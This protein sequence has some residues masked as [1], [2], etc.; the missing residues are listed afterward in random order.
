M[1]GFLSAPDMGKV[2]SSLG[3]SGISFSV[4][5]LVEGS[6]GVIAAGFGAL[7]AVWAWR[8]GRL[9]YRKAQVALEHEELLLEQDRANAFP[10]KL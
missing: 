3:L 10:P 6:L 5:A 2:M 7:A 4:S 8:T 1:K 9:A